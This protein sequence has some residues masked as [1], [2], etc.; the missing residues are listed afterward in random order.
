[1]RPLHCDRALVRPCTTELALR[2]DWKAEPLSWEPA[3]L[4]FY[5]SLFHLTA[6][7]LQPIAKSLRAQLRSMQIRDPQFVYVSN[8]KAMAIRSALGIATDLADNIARS[9]GTTLLAAVAKW[10]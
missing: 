6:P 7:L 8:V 9:D 3:K 4:S 2:S 10:V 1:V 5:M